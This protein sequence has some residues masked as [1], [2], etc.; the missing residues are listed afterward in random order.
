MNPYGIID[1]RAELKCR[2]Q[3]EDVYT[4]LTE[5]EVI[6]LGGKAEEVWHRFSADMEE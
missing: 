3:R 4:M 5:D 2:K 6:T 1:P